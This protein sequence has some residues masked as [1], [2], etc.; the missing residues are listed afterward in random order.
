MLISVQGIIVN[1]IINYYYYISI[2][3]FCSAY[4]L[5]SGVP[6]SVCLS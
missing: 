2:N 1:N 3:I 6:I 5:L 4:I